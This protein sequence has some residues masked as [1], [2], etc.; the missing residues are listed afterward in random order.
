MKTLKYVWPIFFLSTAIQ[1]QGLPEGT[2][3][4]INDQPL[5]EQLLLINI[6]ANV[7]RGVPDTPQLRDQLKKELIGQEILAQESRKLNLD[8]SPQVQAALQQRQQNL[9]A[10]LALENHA[11]NTPVTDAQIKAE[12]DNFVQN[13]KNEKEYKISIITVPT[14]ARADEILAQL[15]KSK[16]SSLFAKLASAESL[17]Q[18]KSNAGSLDWLLPAQ[19]IPAVSNVVVNVPKGKLSNVPI[20]VNNGWSI[21]RVDDIRNYTPP[22]M[23]AIEPNLRQAIIQKALSAY[24]QDLYK[25]AKIVQ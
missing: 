11:R 16:D 24:A 4:I 22:D 8:K 15:I 5:S 9:L 18:S 25:N 13:R 20:Q 10:N 1:A 3:A 19:I 6:N 12:Y 14:K 21:V 23:K 2:F 17:D 7:E